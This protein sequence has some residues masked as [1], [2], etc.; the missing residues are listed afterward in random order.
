ML[1]PD[2]PLDVLPELDAP[3]DEAPE[4]DAPLDVVPELDEVESS[5]PP[6]ATPAKAKRPEKARKRECEASLAI[7]RAA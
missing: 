7:M 4:V 3:L 5:P 2:A 1:E 6:Q